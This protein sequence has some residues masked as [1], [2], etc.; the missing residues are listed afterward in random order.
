MEKYEWRKVG[1]IYIN[2]KVRETQL[3]GAESSALLTKHQ[4]Y[5]AR[6]Y[7][8]LHKLGCHCL[9]FKDR[10]PKNAVRQLVMATTMETGNMDSLSLYS[11]Y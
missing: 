5:S 8:K 1:R 6:K 3:E 11:G 9:Q 4:Y 2:T 7:T 10:Q